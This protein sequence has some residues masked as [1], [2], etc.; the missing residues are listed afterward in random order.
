MQ[1]NTAPLPYVYGRVNGFPVR[2]RNDLGQPSIA[3]SLHV[4][5]APDGLLAAIDAI[6]KDAPL[7]AEAFLAHAS[8]NGFTI[9][10]SAEIEFPH[11]R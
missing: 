8:A 5:F 9:D 6:E 4:R 3:R 1:R 10:A 11:T 7:T 2:I